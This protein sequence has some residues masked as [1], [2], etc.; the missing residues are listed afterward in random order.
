MEKYIRPF[1]QRIVTYDTQ[2]SGFIVSHIQGSKVATTQI[3]FTNSIAGNSAYYLVFFRIRL[4]KVGFVEPSRS[5][6]KVNE[7]TPNSLE[8]GL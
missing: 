1:S 3:E 4:P 6:R 7:S 5:F 2:R 8:F